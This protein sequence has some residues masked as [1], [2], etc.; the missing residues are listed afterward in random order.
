MINR[1]SAGQ[2]ATRQDVALEATSRQPVLP[3]LDINSAQGAVQM[4]GFRNESGTNRV[5]IH[6]G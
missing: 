5:G 3:I 1:C 6:S 4:E 2:I